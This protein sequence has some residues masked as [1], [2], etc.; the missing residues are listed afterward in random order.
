MI[1]SE[2]PIPPGLLGLFYFDLIWF[3]LEILTYNT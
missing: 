2:F 3:G 1:G